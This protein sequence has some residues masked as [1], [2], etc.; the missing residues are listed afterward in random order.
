MIFDLFIYLF[1]QYWPSKVSLHIF[2]FLAWG[3]RVTKNTKKKL[4]IALFEANSKE[5]C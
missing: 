4:I 5:I 2:P 1:E 3:I